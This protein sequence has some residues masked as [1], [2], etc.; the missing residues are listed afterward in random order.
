[1]SLCASASNDAITTSS[2]LEN[3]PATSAYAYFIESNHIIMYMCMHW[4]LDSYS[5]S[6]TIVTTDIHTTDNLSNEQKS[7]CSSQQQKVCSK[8]IKNTTTSFHGNYD[9]S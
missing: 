9:L 6:N 7:L 4:T 2:S 3:A 5:V 1:M 8:K